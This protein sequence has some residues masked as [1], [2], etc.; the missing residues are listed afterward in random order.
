MRRV[1]KGKKSTFSLFGSSND[2]SL[3][4][5]EEDERFKK[6]MLVDV[7]ALGK[8]AEA[9]GVTVDAKGQEGVPGWVGLKDVITRDGGYPVEAVLDFCF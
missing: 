3:T 7:E 9:L 2:Q 5:E 1:R 6:Q 8:D 4:A